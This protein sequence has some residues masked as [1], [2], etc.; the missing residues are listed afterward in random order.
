MTWIIY[1]VLGLIAIILL[2]LF[3]PIHLTIEYDKNL[4]FYVRILFFKFSF[5]PSDYNNISINSS[6]TKINQDN[7]DNK[8]LNSISNMIKKKELIRVLKLITNVLKA[9]GNL[10]VEIFKK[11][12]VH[13][14]TF[15]LNLGGND[16]YSIAIRYG[17]AC[18]VI[19]SLFGYIISIK[20][21]AIYNV[22]VMPNFDSRITSLY[23]KITLTMTAWSLFHTGIKHLNKIKSLLQN[24]EV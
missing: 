5:S 21:P 14:L 4:I 24:L 18:S 11:I 15:L 7:T 6:N 16:A 1:L 19:Y 8:N 22:Q 3:T 12:N 17:Q 2:L 23:S 9:S 10:F 20:S 13:N